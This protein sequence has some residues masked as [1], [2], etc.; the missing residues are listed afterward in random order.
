[1]SHTSTLEAD[2]CHEESA[3]YCL[4]LECSGKVVLNPLEKSLWLAHAHQET[5]KPPTPSPP[6]TKLCSYTL[7]FNNSMKKHKNHLFFLLK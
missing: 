1:M 4:V 2:G 6:N 3:T 5:Y 7:H